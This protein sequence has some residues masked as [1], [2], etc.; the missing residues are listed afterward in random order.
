MK[1]FLLKVHWVIGSQFGLDPLRFY[2]SLK[3]LPFF[4]LDWI[5]FRRIYKGE[6]E[7]KPCLH[8]RFMEG[9]VTKSEY[10][11]QDLLVSRWIFK[12][13]PTCHVDIGSRIDGFVAHVASFREIEVLDV[14]PIS[15]KIPGVTFA[16]ADLMEP[17]NLIGNKNANNYCD[18]LSCLHTLEHFGLGRYGD[19]IDTNGY[20]KGIANMSPLIKVGG[21]L[22]LST[23]IGRERVEFNA[24]RIFDPSTIIEVAKDNNL[25]AESIHSISNGEVEIISIDDEELKKLSKKDYSLGIFTFIKI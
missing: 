3:G 14:R 18:S 11:W 9:G 15:T 17:I 19:N 1:K 20:K 13:K 21:R 8:D 23:P 7:I 6:M 22:Y 12:N 24:N 2:R 10:F 25:K 16:Q 5:K 4:I